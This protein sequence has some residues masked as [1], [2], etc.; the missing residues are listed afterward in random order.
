MNFVHRDQYSYKVIQ[1]DVI[2]LVDEKYDINFV[3]SDQ[4]SYTVLQALDVKMCYFFYCH[5]LQSQTL[6]F[7]DNLIYNL[8]FMC[9]LY[10]STHSNKYQFKNILHFNFNLKSMDFPP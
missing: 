3:H 4:Y 6:L 1:T 7:L 2:T 9:R 8:F 10:L 5:S